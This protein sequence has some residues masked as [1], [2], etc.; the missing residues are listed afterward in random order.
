MNAMAG[1]GIETLIRASAGAGLCLLGSSCAPKLTATP[2]SPVPSARMAA[3]EEAAARSD[4]S[5]IPYLIEDLESDDPAV[6]FTAIHALESITGETFG[7]RH[8]DPPWERS[9]AIERWEAAWKS[10]RWSGSST[11]QP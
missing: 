3:A 4:A 5:A 9:E 6:R 11:T 8:F 7:Y 1:T 2:D 10:G